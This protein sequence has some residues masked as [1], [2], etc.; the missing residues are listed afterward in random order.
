MSR[1]MV[2][3]VASFQGLNRKQC[4][5]YCVHGTWYVACF[6]EQPFCVGHVR[7]EHARSLTGFFIYRLPKAKVK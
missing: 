1:G 4:I 2:G 5:I 3:L 6:E 7:S